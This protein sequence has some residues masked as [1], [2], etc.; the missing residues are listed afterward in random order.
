M[1]RKVQIFPYPNYF[2][3]QLYRDPNMKESALLLR[4]KDYWKGSL[5]KSDMGY[6]I[7]AQGTNKQSMMF[8]V[9]PE[10]LMYD[11]YNKGFNKDF[12]YRLKD[13]ILLFNQLFKI[14]D[15][16]DDFSE[17]HFKIIRSDDSFYSHRMGYRIYNFQL[18]SV[19]K[20]KFRISDTISNNKKYTLLDF[21]GTWCVPR[22][23]LTHRLKKINSEFENELN[24][25]GVAYKDSLEEVKEYV[26]NKRMPILKREK[27]L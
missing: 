27:V 2:L 7:Y 3:T 11:L 6:K 25:I 15:L 24:L 16:T 12:E 20:T 22:T 23:K 19:A 14:D 17:L 1:S 13:T 5:T 4:L 9:R 8:V 10:S 21:W 18:E 26:S